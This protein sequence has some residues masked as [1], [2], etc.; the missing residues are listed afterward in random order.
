MDVLF[1]QSY[2][3]LEQVLKIPQMKG[4]FVIG[5]VGVRVRVSVEVCVRV[6]IRIRKSTNER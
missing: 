1:Y 3:N 4:E 6:N 2:R 5:R